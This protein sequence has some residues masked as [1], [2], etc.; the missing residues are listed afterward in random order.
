[1][2]NPVTPTKP[3]QFR[4]SEETLRELSEIARH[5]TA[6]LGHD[7]NDTDAVRYAVRQTHR[8]IFSG[9]EK[10]PSKKS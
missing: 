3:R 8:K 1:M 2:P 6:E 9:K 5:L 10:K 7:Q 4:L